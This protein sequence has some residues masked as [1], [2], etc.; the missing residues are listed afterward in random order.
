MDQMIVIQNRGE[1]ALSLKRLDSCAIRGGAY[2]GFERSQE[3]RGWN[4]LQYTV[5]Y[6][7][8]G[9]LH[10]AHTAERGAMERPRYG[11]VQ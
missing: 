8:L 3:V 1:E 11:K 4:D 6:M 7:H 2:V 10:S 5:V 9:W